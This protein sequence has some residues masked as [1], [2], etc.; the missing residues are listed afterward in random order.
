[1]KDAA[2]EVDSS[3]IKLCSFLEIALFELY[4]NSSI[5]HCV[6]LLTLGSV[7]MLYETVYLGVKRM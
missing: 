4:T 7:R 2:T 3:I 5:S 1:M 6:P